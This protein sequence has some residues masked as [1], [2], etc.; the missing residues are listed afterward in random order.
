MVDD[1]AVG[2]LLPLPNSSLEPL[3][4]AP[5]T[6]APVGATARAETPDGF[7]HLHRVA[8]LRRSD[9]EEVAAELMTWQIHRRAGL[10]VLAGSGRVRPDGVVVLRLGVGRF[11]VR[12]PCRV[13]YVVEDPDRRG[14]AYGT[15]PGHP[16]SGEERFVLSRA[17]DG[18]VDF[19]ITAFSRHAT[20]LARL[21][22]PVTPALQG[23]LTR[24][25]LAAADHRR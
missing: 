1:G 20:R 7:R 5:L 17:S 4:A 23:L 16:E 12:A 13:V 8:R 3:T 15:L 22:G 11:A 10:T 2:Q 19:T 18:R 6:Y 25:Y 14:F 24:R 9:F 21:G